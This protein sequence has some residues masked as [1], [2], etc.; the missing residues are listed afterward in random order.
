MDERSACRFCL[1][2][3]SRRIVERLLVPRSISLGLLPIFIHVGCGLQMKSA[4]AHLCKTRINPLTDLFLTSRS[5]IQE[6]IVSSAFS[7]GREY[8]VARRHGRFRR[9]Y[10]SVS[11]TRAHDILSFMTVI[12]I[13]DSKLKVVFCI[14]S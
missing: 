9:L 4:H 2:P 1:S 7:D 10:H 5:T 12:A 6:F 14:D 8:V 3:D 13:C 11:L